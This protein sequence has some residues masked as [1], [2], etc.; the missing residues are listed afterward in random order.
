[1]DKIIAEVCFKAYYCLY[2]FSQEIDDKFRTNT[3][4]YICGN[5]EQVNLLGLNLESIQP[6]DKVNNFIYNVTYD[7]FVELFD[8]KLHPNYLKEKYKCMKETPTYFIATRDKENYN[9]F[10]NAVKQYYIQKLK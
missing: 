10:I 7:E 9:K 4:E 1:M 5:Y 6:F 8:P 2:D 3:C